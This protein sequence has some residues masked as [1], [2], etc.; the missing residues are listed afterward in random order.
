MDFCIKEK[1]D[2]SRIRKNLFYEDIL[3]NG[4]TVSVHY[5]PEDVAEI[6]NGKQEF[7]FELLKHDP[8]E[9]EA[10]K[11]YRKIHATDGEAI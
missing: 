11:R 8:D 2:I 3:K 6:F 1:P 10:F 5:S 7:D 4:F 9:L